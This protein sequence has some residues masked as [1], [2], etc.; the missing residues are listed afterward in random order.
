MVCAEKFAEVLKTI[1][2]EPKETLLVFTAKE[3]N[4]I[5]VNISKEGEDRLRNKINTML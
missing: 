4:R 5:A 3:P 1:K 2:L